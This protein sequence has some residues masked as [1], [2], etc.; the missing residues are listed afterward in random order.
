MKKHLL[1]FLFTFFL[2]GLGISQ[3]AEGDIAFVDYQSDGD[4]RFAFVV[5]NSIDEADSIN[6]TDNGWIDSS[7]SLRLNEGAITWKPPAGGVDC[8][9][10]VT[11]TTNSAANVGSVS[12]LDAGMI[13]STGGDQ[14][15]AFTGTLNTPTIIAGIQMNGD[16]DAE[17]TSSN[18]SAMP[19]TGIL[20]AIAP[21]RDNAKYADTSLTDTRVNVID[22]LTNPANWISDNSALPAYSGT[23]DVTDCA[24]LAVELLSFTAKAEG[25]DVR[26]N[27]STASE[28]DNDFFAVEFSIDGSHF[29][30]LGIVRG[31]GYSNEVKH[32][33]F[34]HENLTQ[35][36]YFYRLRQ[37]NFDRSFDFS[38]VERVAIKG[39]S[40]DIS[41]FPT[42]VKERVT[43]LS[44]TNGD[45]EIG[46]RLFNSA[47]QQL[48]QQ[49]ITAFETSVDM[50]NFHAGM[51]IL[52][53]SKGAELTTYKI[54]RQ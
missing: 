49:Q 37:V 27:W 18:H 12:V 39:S 22:S 1:F 11:I 10:L 20:I 43:I 34:M 28:L 33:D 42:L 32:Y 53:I 52:H 29:E 38:S 45:V 46:L 3:V 17:A 44:G 25:T 21:E 19:P 47:G 7:Q 41:V 14:V 5:L 23:F 48:L 54:I 40:S 6:F 51:Y 2:C 15:L 16:W 9:T 35:G 13:I 4:D 24:P 8:N 31:A 50:S 36:I 26:L 30:E